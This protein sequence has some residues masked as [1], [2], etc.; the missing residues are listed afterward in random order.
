MWLQSN[1]QHGL[2]WIA[3]KETGKRV[4]LRRAV[5][6]KIK[7]FEVSVN[8]S[9]S[10]EILGRGTRTKQGSFGMGLASDG[11]GGRS[12]WN[13]GGIKDVILVVLR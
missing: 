2:Q 3:G 4:I 13:S 10:F 7:R 9:K 5:H 11:S 8:D 6:L 12:P 1:S